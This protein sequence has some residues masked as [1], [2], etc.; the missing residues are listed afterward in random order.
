MRKSRQAYDRLRQELDRVCELNC[1]HDDLGC[2][3]AQLLA[4]V[5]KMG[6]APCCKA[7]A[8]AILKLSDDKVTSKARRLFDD[9]F[10]VGYSENQWV[11]RGLSEGTADVSDHGI[12]LRGNSF[13]CPPFVITIHV[14]II[15]ILNN[16]NPM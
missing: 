14:Y 4:L 13:C 7:L 15:E 9:T 10:K 6:A 11:K 3:A 2:A 12:S 5:K 16:P 1:L 8:S